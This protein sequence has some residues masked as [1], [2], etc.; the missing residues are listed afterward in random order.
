MAKAKI[1]FVYP[2]KE[3]YPIIP[4][5]ISIMSGILKSQG[6]ETDLFD[7]T[8]MTGECVDLKAREKSGLVEK[9]DLSSIWKSE[10]KIDIEEEFKKKILEFNPDLIA[11]SIVENNFL[12]SKKL[13]SLAKSVSSAYILVGGLFPTVATQ[14]F[15][16]DDNVDFICIGEGEY[17]ISELVK[18]IVEKGDL[19]DI[20]NLITTI[21]SLQTSGKTTVN[22]AKYYDWTPLVLQDW[23][24]FD[25]RHL[26]KPFM[27]KVYKTGC[28]ELSRGCPNNCFYC[29]N[30]LCQQLYKGL[31]N[32]NRE[33]PIQL[34]IEE[35]KQMKEKHQLELIFFNDENFLQM[36]KERLEEFSS[37]YK[38]NINLPFFVATRADSLLNKNKVEM[39]KDSGCVTVGIGVECGN[40]EFRRKILNKN[41]KNEVYEQ[42]FKNCHEV[43]LRTTA[44]IMIGLP[45]ETEENII[46]SASFCKKIEAKSVSLAIFAPYFGTELRRICVENNFMKDEISDQIGICNSSILTMPQIS[47]EKIDDLFC[48]FKNLVYG[49]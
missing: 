8:F 14:F 7:A 16:E 34:A 26:M 22:L 13:C 36:K 9:V 31:G 32:Y 41:L 49:N 40:E 46:E 19:T 11:F 47:K 15:I 3:G 44:N 35:I 43:G 27:G 39:L 29:V 12:F 17:P 21:P 42:A 10:S 23:D 48:N 6:H 30:K 33:K 4:L 28:F 5:A 2:N 1:L 24:I 37:L 20:P 45:F 38:K 18:R 25:G